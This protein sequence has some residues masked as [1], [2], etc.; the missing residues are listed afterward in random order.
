MQMPQNSVM[1]PDNI[2]QFYEGDIANYTGKCLPL[3]PA[4]F[5]KKW[6]PREQTNRI[7]KWKLQVLLSLFMSNNELTPASTDLSGIQFSVLNVLGSLFPKDQN[8]Y[9]NTGRESGDFLR[10]PYST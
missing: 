8:R 6:I 3:V 10:L 2:T 9:N 4:N 1:I 7:K 5:G